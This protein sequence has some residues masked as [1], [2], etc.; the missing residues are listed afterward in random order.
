MTRNIAFI[1]LTRGILA[2]AAMIFIF[3]AAPAT[4][5]ETKG[6]LTYPKGTVALKFSYLVTGPDAI[7]TAKIIRRL[8]FSGND[9]AP[10]IQACQTMSCVD[11]EITEG[12][13]VDLV[14]GPRFNYWMA[15]NNALVQYSGTKEMAALKT[16]AD[17]PKRMAGKLSFDDTAAG[18]P[19]VDVDFDA[20]LAKTFTKAR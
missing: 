14:G 16:N 4:A 1:R 17:D 10:K 9:L 2:L 15:L 11:G 7:D 3:S 18:G 19:K 8:I 20:A 6:T 5:G 13:M 12:L